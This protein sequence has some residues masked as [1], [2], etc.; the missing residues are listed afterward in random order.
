MVMSM[1]KK[2]VPA[3]DESALLLLDLYI[4]WAIMIVK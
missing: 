1:L 4:R 3:R 2:V